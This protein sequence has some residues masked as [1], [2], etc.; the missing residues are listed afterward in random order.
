[1]ARCRERFRGVREGF[2][3]STCIGGERESDLEMKIDT[4]MYGFDELVAIH[5]S[6]EGMHGKA[7]QA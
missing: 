7:L 4:S 5:F 3:N 1:M 2:L 6:Q